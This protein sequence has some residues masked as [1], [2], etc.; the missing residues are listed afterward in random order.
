MQR[1]QKTG[2]LTMLLF[3]AV[4][5]GAAVTEA[6]DCRYFGQVKEAM[7]A[8][9]RLN[10]LHYTYA[11]SVYDKNGSEV[12]KAEV[13]ADQLTGGWQAEYSVTDEDG[14][15]P[16]LR[17]YCDGKSVYED[18][19]WDGEWELCADEE[20]GPPNIEELTMLS[21]DTKD[22]FEENM[23]QEDGYTVISHVLTAEYAAELLQGD[24][25]QTWLPNGNHAGSE[26][27]ENAAL[28][29]YRQTE[30]TEAEVTYWLDKKK[31]L[32]KKEMAV[33]LLRPHVEDALGSI[34][35]PT[36][37]EKI[38]MATNVEVLEYNDHISKGH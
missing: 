11:G 32:C 26:T 12:S 3:M 33:T 31:V 34:K 29:Q 1:E 9:R 5:S 18:K 36:E 23:R 30:V 27:N 15:W 22:I 38:Y 16:F 4:L 10:N 20:L 7:R 13:W 35:M 14:E 37:E 24:L 21:Y 2:I 6:S 25:E 19:D 17:R 8:V 28:E